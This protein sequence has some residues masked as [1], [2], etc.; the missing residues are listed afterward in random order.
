MKLKTDIYERLEINEPYFMNDKLKYF[1]RS[2]YGKFDWLKHDE[3]EGV[4]DL[5]KVIGT[6]HYNYHGNTWFELLPTNQDNHKNLEVFSSWQ[7]QGKLARGWQAFDMLL[8]NPDYFI[9]DDVK[10]NLNYFKVGDD[11][12]ING[13]NHRT[14]L[15]RFLLNLNGYDEM[16]KGVNITEVII[17]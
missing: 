17:P 12:Y 2:I 11:Y 15:G 10:E 7:H 6:A 5:S 1:D 16:I 9:S 4:I 14:I 3:G 13:G 8:R